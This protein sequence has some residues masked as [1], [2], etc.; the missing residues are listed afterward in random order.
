MSGVVA[1]YRHRDEHAN[2]Q[3]RRINRSIKE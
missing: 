1:L 2:L 3:K